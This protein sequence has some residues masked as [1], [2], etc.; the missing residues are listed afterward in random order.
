[1]SKASSTKDIG[2]YNF[3]DFARIVPLTT[4]PLRL[5]SLDQLRLIEF[6]ILGEDY[7]TNFS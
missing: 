3:A 1:M 4:R 2:K 7:N 6:Y 5:K